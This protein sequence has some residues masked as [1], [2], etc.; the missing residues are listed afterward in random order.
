[1]GNVLKLSSLEDRRM[2]IPKAEM[3][4]FGRDTYVV[5]EEEGKA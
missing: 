3:G 2:L 4:S 1:M 5:G